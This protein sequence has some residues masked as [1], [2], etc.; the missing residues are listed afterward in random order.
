MDTTMPSLS[1]HIAQRAAELPE[2]SLLCPRALLHLGSRAAVDQALSRLTRRGQLKR[3]IRSL[4]AQSLIHN[5]GIYL[6]SRIEKCDWVVV[7]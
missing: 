6:I 2:G 7:P 1:Q 4:P 5:F 3:R